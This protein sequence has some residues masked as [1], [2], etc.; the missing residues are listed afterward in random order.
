MPSSVVA[1]ASTAVAIPRYLLRIQYDGTNFHGFQRQPNARTVQGCIEKAL[2]QFAGSEGPILTTGS[3][4]TDAGVHATD[5]T[6]HVD[7][8]RTSKRHPGRAMPPHAPHTVMRAVNHFLQKSAPDA[9]VAACMRVDPARFHARFS[10][11]GRTYHYRVHVSPAPPS[12]FERGRVWHVAAGNGTGVCAGAAAA[13]RDGAAAA[14]AGGKVEEV[15]AAGDEG[16]EDAGWG[17]LDI[18]AMRDAASR[19]LGTHDFSSFRAAGCQ[20]T[21]PVRTLTSLSIEQTPTWPPFPNTQAG[22][23]AAHWPALTHLRACG[24]RRLTR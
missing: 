23:H 15:G 2:G 12:I 5:A 4:R 1:A 7:L 3:S 17:G 18:D 16:V 9:C 11:T 20:A 22:T 6:A 24:S 10:A 13:A 19:L 8:T 14:G 21:S